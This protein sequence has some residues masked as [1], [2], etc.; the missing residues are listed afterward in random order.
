MDALTKAIADLQNRSAQQNQAYTAQRDAQRQSVNQIM[1]Q[2]HYTNILNQ[3]MGSYNP[4]IDAQKSQIADQYTESGRRI[5]VDAERRGLYNSGVA[6]ELQR[7]N[8]VDQSQAVSQAL[9]QLQA[10][11]VEDARA[12]QQQQLQ[13][14]NMS[15]DWTTADRGLDQ[16]DL[17]TWLDS[18]SNLA[19]LGMENRKIDIGERQT[20]RK[21]DLDERQVD[22]GERQ[23][24]E[25][26]ALQEQEM[27]QN[28]EL[29]QSRLGLDREKFDESVTQFT[30]SF[31]FETAKH[32]D[33]VKQWAVQN[34]MDWAK[35]DIQTKSAISDAVYKTQMGNIA[36]QELA[37]SKEKFVEDKY[38]IAL[39]NQKG[40]IEDEKNGYRFLAE[41][42]TTGASPE[43]LREAMGVFK[44]YSPDLYSALLESIDA[45]EV[46]ALANAPAPQKS[47]AEKSQDALT[48]ALS[49]GILGNGTSNS[50]GIIPK[51]S[52]LDAVNKL[53][54][55]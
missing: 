30:K 1:S 12:Y 52:Q 13:A 15:G 23:S 7:R 21:I 17:S 44:N 24:D 20:D 6:G 26:L 5:D 51:Q 34:D 4:L 29:A 27:N 35:I 18:S 46:L 8:N 3:I 25:K 22:I 36:Q 48:K 47:L 19:Q 32:G 14:V 33:T 41:L 43:E 37:L 49:S 28:Y 16:N 53:W 50:G 40:K 45:E 39:E 2:D 54:G 11:A 55:Q 10:K 42:R 31:D 38:L 9:A